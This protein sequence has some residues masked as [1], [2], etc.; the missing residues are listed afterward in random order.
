M[1]KNIKKIESILA[2]NNSD[3]DFKTK[4]KNYKKCKQYIKK[5]NDIIKKYEQI[6]ENQELD[7][8]K[9]NHSLHDID[10]NLNNKIEELEINTLFE[11]LAS[12]KNVKL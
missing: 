1:E 7:N 6:L 11:Y 2:Q 9:N 12:I 3:I 5:S 10:R 8:F 4:I